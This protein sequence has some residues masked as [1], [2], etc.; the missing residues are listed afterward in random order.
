MIHAGTVLRIPG[1]A[2]AQAGPVSGGSD[3]RVGRKAGSGAAK[4][5]KSTYLVQARDSLWK[6]ARE[7]N[8]SVEDLKRWNGVDEKTLR[9]GSVLVV[10][11]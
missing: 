3:G 5:A 4:A 8:V 9:A 2:V 1:R 10:E 7:H 11:Q 6:I